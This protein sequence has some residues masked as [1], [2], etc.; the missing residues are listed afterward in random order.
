MNL[1]NYQQLI[2]KDFPDFK[3]QD[4]KYLGSGWDNAAVLVNGDYVF[5]FLRGIFDKNYPLKTED[6][7]KEVNILNYLQGKTSFAAPKPD[8]VAPDASYFGYKLIPGTLWDQAPDHL[9]DEYLQSWVATRSEISKVIGKSEAVNLKVPNYGT[10]KNEALARAYIADPS[11]D[12]RVVQMA[13]A[14]MDYVCTRCEPKDSW[15][16]IHEDLQLSNCM[17]DTVAKKITGVIDWMEAEVGPVEA[18]FYFWSKYGKEVL[19][20]VA[21]LQQEYDGTVIDPKLARCIHQFYIVAD[22]QDFKTRGFS[23]AADHK[24]R[25]IEA[26]L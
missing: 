23:E 22:Y 8:F 18:E 26:Y 15:A 4:L 20:K 11:A 2:Q 3:I 10:D 7:Q 21:A 24:W 19:H 12:P 13:Q 5:R 1:D 9:S 16:F 17:V 6:V 25:Q 14:A